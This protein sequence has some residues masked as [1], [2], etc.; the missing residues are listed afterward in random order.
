MNTKRIMESDTL[1]QEQ[2]VRLCEH[3]AMIDVLKS[4]RK[5]AASLMSSEDKWISTM[6]AREVV[7]IDKRIIKASVLLRS[8]PA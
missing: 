6:A 7:A 2:K 5:E 3:F 8:E 1:T 4:Q